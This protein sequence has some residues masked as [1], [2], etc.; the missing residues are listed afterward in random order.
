MIY[1]KSNT[2][3]L[4][5]AVLLLDAPEGTQTGEEAGTRVE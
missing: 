2:E 4:K 1:A 5:K 3:L